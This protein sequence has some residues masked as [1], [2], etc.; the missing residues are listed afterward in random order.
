LEGK[1]YWEAI[2]SPQMGELLK[3]AGSERRS[4]VEEL[5]LGERVF[6][7]S[8]TPLERGED[9]VVIFHDITEIKNAEKVKKDFVVN[10]S[11][12]LHTPLTVIKGY[13]ETLL[14]EVPAEPGKRYIEIIQRNTDRLINI[15]N[16]LLLLS[17]LEER[18]PLELEDIDL[19][20]FI[21]NVVRI[22][23]QR[24][25]DKQ[26]SLVVEMKENLPTI[27]ADLFKLEQV[28][29]NLLDNAV[30]Y[31]E[32]GRIVVSVDVRDNR[33]S[34][35][36]RDTGIGIPKE[37]IPR[38]FERFYVVD[39][40]RSRKSGGTGLGLS[41]VKHIV[42]LHNGAINIESAPG[43]GTTVTVT[44]PTDQSAS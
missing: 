15:V 44:L 25:K 20:N 4:F 40:S 27:K 26:L 1:H 16:D 10:V 32:R 12:E 18:T 28:M 34:I 5:P 23:D 38:I 9:I 13:A 24:L 39:K 42:L 43:E 22:F 14:Q 6:V 19:R 30:K 7:F 31:T 2:R 33:A 8:V 41:I 11:H 21:E 37:A 17:S 29:V 35:Q 36:V 3:K